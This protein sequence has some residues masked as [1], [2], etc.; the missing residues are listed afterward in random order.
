MKRIFISTIFLCLLAASMPAQT[1][2]SR[3]VPGP[4][5]A[6]GTRSYYDRETVRWDGPRK[7]SVI[8][9]WRYIRTD[10]SYTLCRYELHRNRYSRSWLWYAYDV[11]GEMTDSNT[12]R[13]PWTEIPPDT[14]VEAFY[15]LFF[16]TNPQPPV[17]RY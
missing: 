14:V 6:T 10:G 15:D 11:R 5:G 3:W 17:N 13:T 1:T 7:T 16:A 2:P 4:S 9:W 8:F 12:Q